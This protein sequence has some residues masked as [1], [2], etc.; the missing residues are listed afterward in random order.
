MLRESKDDC[1]LRTSTSTNLVMEMVEQSESV[2]F[3]PF[4]LVSAER[5]LERE[6]APV[7]IG[8]R[9]LDILIFLVAHAGEV[10]GKS[11]VV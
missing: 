6:G 2:S 7:A 8:S 9:A 11:V 4:R 1:A 3:G 10:V 5:L